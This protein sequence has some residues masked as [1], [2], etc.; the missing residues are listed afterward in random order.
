MATE[1]GRPAPRKRT[2]PAKAAPK[3]APKP[4]RAEPEPIE[5]EVLEPMPVKKGL[6]FGFSSVRELLSYILGTGILI[7]GVLEAPPDRQLI[8]VGAGLSLLGLPIVGGIFDK[9]G[10]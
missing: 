1:Q 6:A 5:V 2:R 4:V 10:P 3:P 7:Y 9:K 8:V